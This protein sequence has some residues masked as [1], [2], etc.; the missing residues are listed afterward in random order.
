[1]ATMSPSFEISS[2]PSYYL[3]S[4]IETERKRLICVVC[5][6]IARGFNF[7][8]ITCMSCKIFFRRNAF[9]NFNSL[10]CHAGGNCEINQQTRKCCTYCRLLTCFRVGMKRQ[11]FRMKENNN[12]KWS[13]IDKQQCKKELRFVS[14]LY[15]RISTNQ[16]IL[17]TNPL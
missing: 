3:F 9:T 15:Q 10:Y 6:S 17:T 1:M 8:A 4:N 13:Q 12:F 7:G 2:V 14:H 11:L 16:H 5:G